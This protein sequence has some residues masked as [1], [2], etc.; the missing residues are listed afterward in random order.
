MPA[1]KSQQSAGGWRIA[2]CKNN[3]GRSLIIPE[4]ADEVIVPL[5]A[6]GNMEAVYDETITKPEMVFSQAK[7]ILKIPNPANLIPS[8]SAASD[9]PWQ[10][11]L[12]TA[13]NTLQV[14]GGY[15]FTYT[16]P[17][18][19]AYS[20]ENAIWSASGTGVDIAFPTLLATFNVWLELTGF[21]AVVNVGETPPA[22]WTNV[23]APQP[24]DPNDPTIRGIYVMVGYVD[25]TTNPPT[26]TQLLHHNPFLRGVGFKEVSFGGS[27]TVA[28]VY[29]RHTILTHSGVTYIRTDLFYGDN[30][31]T[32]GGGSSDWL[33][34]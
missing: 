17:T 27:W 22:D 10:I 24:I 15:A 3:P 13:A 5:N 20:P 30:G 29:R 28:G 33:A 23:P 1:K 18:I 16:G 2:L 11:T 8:A 9:L 4:Q 6:L 21:N 34:I 7:V 19:A 14:S 32:P 12:G 26:I 25:P 31:G